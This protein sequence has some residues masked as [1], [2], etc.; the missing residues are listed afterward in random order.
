MRKAKSVHF[1]KI[2]V[3]ITHREIREGRLEARQTPT[4]VHQVGRTAISRLRLRQQN[5]PHLRE[6]TGD[7]TICGNERDDVIDARQ[8][9]DTVYGGPGDDTLIGGEDRDVLKGE[10]GNDILVGGQG[11][12]T[13]DGGDGTDTADY[14]KEAAVNVN[15]DGSAA[16]DPVE[17]NLAD[18]HAVDTYGDDDTLENIENVKGT[19][20]EDTITG[21]GG[22]NHIDG[23]GG[24]D[25]INGGAGND[26]I[27]YD[28]NDTS[29]PVDVDG[30]D[31][32]DTLIVS[33]DATLGG[34]GAAGT[35]GFENLQ[36][37]A[38]VGTT[39]NLTGD[40]N[41]NALTGHEGVNTLEGMG[42]DDR[43]NGGAGADILRGQAGN[44]RL[45]GGSGGDCFEF[46]ATNHVPTDRDQVTDFNSGE[47]DTI[48]VSGTI[49]TSLAKNVGSSLSA[50]ALTGRIV[51]VEIVTNDTATP[52]NK[53]GTVVATLATIPGLKADDVR[54]ID[55]ISD[56]DTSGTD[57]TEG[58]TNALF[59]NAAAC[60]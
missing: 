7:D 14:G 11:N 20:G 33:A 60:N 39:V 23:G 6:T 52:P 53:R 59:D 46:S 12:D 34:T 8:G 41:D 31:G 58:D 30:G 15:E 48:K 50:R 10:A 4:G 18:K 13:L 45:T 32:E 2:Q 38:E 28:S 21:D 24:N 27:V 16:A 47:G 35:V 29:D 25:A 17:V 56:T 44:D 9:D 26:S 55:I 19:P 42:G 54:G 36:A 3:T 40:E 37:K 1:Q 49:P 51:I 43:L 5:L 57:D 22:S